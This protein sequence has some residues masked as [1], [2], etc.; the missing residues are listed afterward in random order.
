MQI[1][2][3]ICSWDLRD[4][5]CWC[6]RWVSI[7]SYDW[8][9]SFP[10]YSQQVFF[11]YMYKV[12]QHLPQWLHVIGMLPHPDIY[13]G[14]LRVDVV[15]VGG[16]SLLVLMIEAPHSFHTHIRSSL[17][18]QHML[19]WLQVTRMLPHPDTDIC[20]LPLGLESG[21]C[22]CSRWVSVSC[23]NWGPPFPSYS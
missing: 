21:C 5:C 2:P 9:P 10:S 23:Y 20:P 19:Q 14:D 17:Y 11:I 6:R 16:G 7:I 18:I 22:W 3:V 13:P 8:V 15:G 12:F 4:G 1:Q